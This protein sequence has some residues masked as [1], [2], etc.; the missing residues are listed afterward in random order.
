MHGQVVMILHGQRHAEIGRPIGTL[1]K[2]DT[3]RF[4]AVV[5]GER[6][7][8]VRREDPHH[9]RVEGRGKAAQRADVGELHLG[10]RDFG[11]AMRREIGVGRPRRR[12]SP[13]A[14]SSNCAMS[15]STASPVSSG[16][17]CGRL[18]ASITCE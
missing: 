1:R 18:P 14:A 15:A 17:R 11:G 8:F 3:T 13:G 6:R 12:T 5:E 10:K 4:Q 7:I 9:R 16:E 2:L